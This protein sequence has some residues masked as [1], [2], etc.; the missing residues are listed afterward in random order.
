M[1]GED[2]TPDAVQVIPPSSPPM[3]GAPAAPTSPWAAL[4][5]KTR[6]QPSRVFNDDTLSSDP[7]TSR[8]QRYNILQP[9]HNRSNLRPNPSRYSHPQVEDPQQWNRQSSNTRH[10]PPKRSQHI[11][12]DQAKVNERL[13]EQNAAMNKEIVDLKKM[14]SNLANQM[15]SSMA[16]LSTVVLGRVDSIYRTFTKETP[17][18]IKTINVTGVLR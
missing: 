3:I 2:F 9:N 10:P 15:S 7:I 13:I 6:T 18:A 5:S 12:S 4:T 8:N 1:E 11:S 17:S 16:A 14:I